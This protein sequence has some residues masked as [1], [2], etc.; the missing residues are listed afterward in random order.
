MKKKHLGLYAICAVCALLF[1]GAAAF[2]VDLRGQAAG[3]YAELEEEVVAL[4]EPVAPTEDAADTGDTE[5]AEENP[6]AWDGEGAELA[7]DFDKLLEKNDDT[8]AWLHVPAISISYPVLYYP[9]DND[10]YLNRSFDGSYSSAGVIYLE[11][12]NKKDFSEYNS[13]LYGHNMG[14]G[15][16]FGRLHHIG[17]DKK[18]YEE[19][20]YFYLYFP[21]GEVRRYYVFS[22]YETQSGSSTYFVPEKEQAYDDYVKERRELSL[23]KPEGEWEEVLDLRVEQRAN[24][25][26]LSTCHG[27]AGTTRRF[28]VHGILDGIFAPEDG[29]ENATA[30]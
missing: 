22:F 7:I 28:V 4:R 19:Y 14:D 30:E 20:P 6:F 18:A 29:P 21:G 5:E 25:V 3:T 17:N 2:N 16:M 9:Y 27:A 24:L 26:T 8:I 13:F 15:S 10:Y 12:T 11:H 1:V 23:A